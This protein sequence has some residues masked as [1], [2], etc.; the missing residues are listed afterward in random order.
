MRMRHFLGLKWPICP[1]K[2]FFGK[3]NN[4]IFMYFLAPFIVQNLKKFLEP[5]QSYQDATFLGQNWP[6]ASIIEALN[7]KEYI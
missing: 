4:V 6:I 2:N 1:N 3:V 5:M 7:K